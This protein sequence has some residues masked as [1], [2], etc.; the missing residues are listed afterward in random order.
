MWAGIS[1][2]GATEECI[3]EGILDAPGNFPEHN[4]WD[5]LASQ[6]SKGPDDRAYWYICAVTDVLVVDA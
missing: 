6:Y 5:T 3:F 4:D 1:A 2:R